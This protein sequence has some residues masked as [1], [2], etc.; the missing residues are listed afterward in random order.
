MM[1]SSSIVKKKKTEPNEAKGQGLIDV[2]FSWSLADVLNKDLYKNQVKQIPRTFSSTEHY[3]KSFINPLIEETHANLFSSLERLSRVPFSQVL[4]LEITKDYK[5]PKDLFYK[6]SLKRGNTANDHEPNY[7]PEFE[8]LI[9]LTEV[10]PKCIDD[11]NRPKSPFLVAVVQRMKDGYDHDKLI[12]RSSKPIAFYA[13]KEEHR[14][15]KKSLFVVFLTNLKTNV[16]IWTALNSELEGGNMNIIKTVLQIDP[17]V[18]TDCTLCNSQENDTVVVHNA[19]NAISSFNLDD[20]QKAVV[21]SCLDTRECP[22]QIS[23]KLIWGP[24]GTGKTKTVGS[25]LFALFRMKCRTLTCAPTNIAVLGV[26]TRLVSL[27]RKSFQYDTYGLGD[28]VL[29]CNGEKAKIDDHEDLIDVFLDYRISVLASCFAPMSGWNNSVE[30]MI[31]LLEDT[32][33]LY[34]LY[35]EKEKTKNYKDGDDNEDEEEEIIFGIRKVNNNQDNEGDIYDQDLKDTDKR[36]IWK[37]A[38]VQALKERKNKNK[39]I[40][41]KKEPCQRKSQLK[42]DN[43]L[44]F[45]EFFKMRYEF[46]GNRLTFCLTNLYTHMPTSFISLEVAKEMIKAVDLLK[47][48][49]TLLHTSAFANEGLRE[50]LNGIKDVGNSINCSAKLSLAKTKCLEV[51][52]FLH[53]KLSVV[54]CNITGYYQIRRFC[55]QTTC[56]IF[57]TAS[58]SVKLHTE[59]MAPL[60]LLVIDEAAQL[61]ECESTIPLQLFGLRHVILIGDER[62]LPAMVQ[63]EICEKADFGRSLFERLVL[64]GHKKHLLEVQYRMHPSISLYPNREFYD[65]KILDGPNVKEITYEKRFLQGRMFGSYSFINVAYG[66]EDFDDRHSR[67][68]MVEVAVIVEIV[69]TLFKES[70][71]S[72]QKVRVGCISA[73]KAQVFA[74]Q[75]KLEK[76]YSTD[77]NSN[78]SVSVRS[79]DGFQGG[80]EDV[81][82]ISTVRCNG[83]GS[84]GFLSNRQRTNV[85]LTRARHCLWILGNSATLINSGSVWKKLILDAKS[86]GCFYDANDDKNL[87]QAIEGALVELNQL[88][89][90]LRIE[91]Q[92]FSNA[93]WKVC[94]S[95]DFKKS[96]ARIKNVE[97]RKEV[98]S[99]LEKLSSGWRLHHE[100]DK[101]LDM[102]GTSSELLELYKVNGLLNLAW[103]VDIVKENS[104]DVQ[105]LKVWDILPLSDIPKLANCLDTVFGNYTVDFMNRCKCK[106]FEGNLAIPVTWPTDSSAGRKTFL[107]DD[108]HVWFLE[109]Q[110]AS[111]SLNHAPGPSTNRRER[112][113]ARIPTYNC[114]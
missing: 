26:A 75:H 71:A 101:V 103:S 42:C 5:P 46:I 98:L 91:S 85:A 72:K 105:V 7:E 49:G 76:I 40:Q 1:G 89:T 59:G 73:Y 80:E 43:L 107:A 47:T 96:M 110:V 61:K 68:N 79:V 25:L 112:K 37:K 94:F 56:L 62:Q 13:D 86:R 51:L 65:K 41:N 9:A 14:K 31:C 70:V 34:Q 55:L 81:I 109:S 27:V 57:C 35:L 82:I 100:K 64:L 24:P 18:E 84:V 113:S 23:V 97:V 63:S 67:K 3:M 53:E 52:K 39:K 92:L 78:F 19:R 74:L 93:K 4:S 66:K 83:C 54:P 88:D 20:C 106:R 30:S 22:H 58:S 87:A 45:D 77:A 8:D 32:E 16:R 60:E 102:N 21:L 114:L 50:V 95:D 90:L 111:L 10:R 17:N 104:E 99:L 2:V 6:I 12:I 28:I 15:K 69:A 108:D 36:K 29:F 38:I 44:T 33:L 11:L 48:V